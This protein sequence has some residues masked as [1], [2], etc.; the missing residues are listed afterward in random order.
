[1]LICGPARLQSRNQVRGDLPRHG[2]DLRARLWS[3]A[4]RGLRRLE[5]RYPADWRPHQWAGC[6]GVGQYAIS[7]CALPADGSQYMLF[8]AMLQGG[9]SCAVRAIRQ[10]ES[11][12]GGPQGILP[13]AQQW[14]W[15]R[16]THENG[17][18]SAGGSTSGSC[19]RTRTATPF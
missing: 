14:A 6:G 12:G 17:A 15:G 19:T 13:A 2:Q 4:A 1:M 8:P 7:V 11:R 16:G 9:C 10:L 18:T 3:L 5:Q